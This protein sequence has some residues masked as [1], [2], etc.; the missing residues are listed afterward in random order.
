M[1]PGKWLWQSA[2]VVCGFKPL[3]LIIAVVL[4]MG[5]AADKLG[6]EINNAFAS[7]L[8]RSIHRNYLLDC[9]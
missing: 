2:G 3:V 7:H 8:N 1:P 5:S 6:C 4:L 9:L